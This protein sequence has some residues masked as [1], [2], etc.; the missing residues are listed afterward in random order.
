[1]W[2]RDGKVLFYRSEDRVLAVD[3]VA[4]PTFRAAKPRVLFTHAGKYGSIGPGR[5]WDLS[6]DGRRFLMVKLE[7]VKPQPVSELILIQNWT[8]TLAGFFPR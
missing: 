8:G 3:V 2:A 6:A 1:M 4:S 5:A 7:E